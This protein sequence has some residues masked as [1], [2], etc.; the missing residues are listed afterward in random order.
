MLRIEEREKEG[1]FD[2]EETVDGRFEASN[3]GAPITDMIATKREFLLEYFK[4][5]EK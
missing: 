2:S 4:L 5:E 1:T 3:L